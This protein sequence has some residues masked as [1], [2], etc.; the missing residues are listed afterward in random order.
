MPAYTVFDDLQVAS[1]TVS[2]P[3]SARPKFRGD[4]SSPSAVNTPGNCVV[5]GE[6]NSDSVE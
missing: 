5:G 3:W 1:S 6:R 4:H 2:T